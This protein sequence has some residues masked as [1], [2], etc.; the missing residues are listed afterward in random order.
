MTNGRI[1]C[2]LIITN[3]DEFS[4]LQDTG[5]KISKRDQKKK[6]TERKTNLKPQHRDDGLNDNNNNYD[7]TYADT[8][9]V[10][11]IRGREVTAM[12]FN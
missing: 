5:E 2:G 10:I 1:P 11:H 6:N 4:C 3:T 9:V 12:V 8:S 7:K